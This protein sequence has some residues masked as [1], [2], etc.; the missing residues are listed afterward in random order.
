V[1]KTEIAI[2]RKVTD[3]VVV[4]TVEATAAATG[5]GVAL[6]TSTRSCPGSIHWHFRKIGEPHGTLELTYW[7]EN[8]RLWAK[9]H[10]GRRAKW[11]PGCITK[12]VDELT[13][14]LVIRTKRKASNRSS[15]NGHS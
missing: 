4:A 12:L 15:R 14:R 7:P 6:R 11:I 3:Q 5:L 9:V 2:T 8:K 1:T 13:G 10:P